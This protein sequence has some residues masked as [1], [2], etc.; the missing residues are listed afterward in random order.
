MACG[1][2]GGYFGIQDHGNGH[3]RVL[4]SIWDAGSEMCQGR[5]D[6]S[7]VDAADRVEVLHAASDVEVKRFGG[8]GT[9]AQCLDDATGWSV[10]DVVALCVECSRAPSGRACYAAHVRVGDAGWKHLVSYRVAHGKP[11]G[12]FYSFIEDFRRDHVSTLQERR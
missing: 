3:H 2:N 11:F 9:G 10:G 8:E 12:G 4:F 1:F 7:G 5:D 6:P